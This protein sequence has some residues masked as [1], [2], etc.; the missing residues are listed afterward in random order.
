MGPPLPV[1]C[2]D[3]IPTFLYHVRNDLYTRPSDIQ[4]M[5][6]KIAVTEKE[7]HWIE[8]MALRWDGIRI[9]SAIRH[10]S[11]NGSGATW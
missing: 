6:D 5:Y 10:R 3:R 2:P 11:S 4:A 1:S 9:S 7:L 8:D